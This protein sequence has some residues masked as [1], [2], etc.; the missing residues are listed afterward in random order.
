MRSSESPRA[1]HPRRQAAYWQAAVT[2]MESSVRPA[3]GTGSPAAVI[4]SRSSA[5]VSGCAMDD[6]TPMRTRPSA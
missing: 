6:W 2:Q 5:A 4:N 3:G 1:T